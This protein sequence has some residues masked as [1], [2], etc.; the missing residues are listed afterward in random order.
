MSSVNKQKITWLIFASILSI[1]TIWLY[2]CLHNS[3][4][5]E[6]IEYLN[7]DQISAIHTITKVPQDIPEDQLPQVNRKLKKSLQFYLLDLMTYSDNKQVEQLVDNY[8]LDEL[9]LLLPNFP[10]KVK[11]FFWL[12]NPYILLEI[13]FWSLFGLMANLMYS[14]TLTTSFDKNRI[15]EHIGKI[16]Y[17]PFSAIII[18]LSFNALTNEGSISLDGIGHNVIV[19]SF[20]LGFFTRRTILLIGKVKDLILPSSDTTTA[21]ATPNNILS[22][23]IDLA[24]IPEDAQSLIEE[25]SVILK[26]LSGNYEQTIQVDKTGNYTLEHIPNGDYSLTHKLHTDTGDFLAE[27]NPKIIAL[28]QPLQLEIELK[29]IE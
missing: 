21:P 2:L 14:V 18:Y 1:A 17:T 5:G 6:K 24:S 19:L 10:F 15:P 26:A 7:K 8:S 29:K 9:N 3:N 4:P 25:T 12:R 13:V 28:K 16:F 27:S 23:Q 20:I 11:S 22:G